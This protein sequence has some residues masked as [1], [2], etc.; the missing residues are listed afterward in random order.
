MLWEI[1]RLRGIAVT[2]HSFAA[3]SPRFD[4]TRNMMADKLVGMTKDDPAVIQHQEWVAGLL[5]RPD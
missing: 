1:W 2:A 4:E 5:K 3:D